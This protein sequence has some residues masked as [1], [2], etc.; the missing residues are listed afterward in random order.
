MGR[1]W[2]VTALLALQCLA[3]ALCC[4]V[5]R[6]ENDR[7]VSLPCN[8]MRLLDIHIRL[9]GN[10][11]ADE[12]TK[13]L[14]NGNLLTKVDEYAFD[15]FSNLD[16]LELQNN[17]IESVAPT[18]FAGT[19][20]T[21]LDLSNNLLTTVQSDALRYLPHLIELELAFNMITEIGE[22]AFQHNANL[23]KIDLEGNSL[24][25]FSPHALSPLKAASVR[26]SPMIVNLASNNLTFIEPALEKAAAFSEIKFKI[27]GK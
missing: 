21:K 26:Y 22:S 5:I 17:K 23:E 18:A 14:L 7:S 8:R 1:P 19:R 27:I 11:R 25:Y 9:P 16:V 15:K 2:H 4:S 6:R 3:T 24:R 12:V 20:L 13:I 10:V